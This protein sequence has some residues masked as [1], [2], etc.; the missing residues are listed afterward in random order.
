M[1]VEMDS[2]TNTATIYIALINEGVPVFRPTQG[3]QRGDGLYEVLATTDYDPEDET[4]MFPPGAVVKCE[5]ERHEN[6]DWLV[7]KELIC[8]SSNPI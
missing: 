2:N 5:L 8:S 1:W 3:V 7:A 6:E 4:W